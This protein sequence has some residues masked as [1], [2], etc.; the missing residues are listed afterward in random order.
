MMIKGV[1]CDG[2]IEGVSIEGVSIE[3]QGWTLQGT[4]EMSTEYPDN[5]LH[6]DILN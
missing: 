2:C 1:E 4:V 3:G 6:E 5:S